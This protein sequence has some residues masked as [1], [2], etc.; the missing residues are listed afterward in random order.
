MPSDEE[1]D[2]SRLAIFEKYE[3]GR[4]GG[5]EV[6]DWEDPNLQLYAV[7]DR[8]GFMHKERL[9]PTTPSEKDLE[10]MRQRAL[11]W[12][13]MIGRWETHSDTPM[14]R[15]RIFKGVPDG[16]RTVVWSKLL[17]LD[18]IR[19]EGQYAAAYYAAR[20]KGNYR[21]IEQIDKDI[22][23]RF[24]EH[25][26]F[27]ER[28]GLGQQTLFRILA[29][30]TMYNQELGYCQGMDSIAGLLMMYMSEEDA[31]WGMCRLMSSEKFAMHGLYVNEL[32][33]VREMC[34]HHGTIRQKI[35]PKVNQHLES[36][37][38]DP[39]LYGTKWFMEG[40]QERLPFSLVLRIW[41]VYLYVGDDVMHSMAAL[42][43]KMFKKQLLKQSFE[44][45]HEFMK[46]LPGRKFDND[47][48]LDSLHE[49]L[50]DL[51]KQKL[52]RIPKSASAMFIPSRAPPEYPEPPPEFRSVS[53]RRSHRTSTPNLISS[54]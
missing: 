31:Y 28:Y 52:S 5:V 43:L 42:L 19:V 45:L 46:E 21:D 38:F 8:Y 30:Y 3:T 23:R 49:M 39:M 22:A 1:A 34:A 48:V 47:E 36:M 32:P 53:L 6:E 44:E 13:R 18:E 25:V 24:R 51:S 2:A 54:I 35:M 7:T 4:E 41:D 40:F 20:E 50:Q 10:V 14:F 11:K 12:T 29:A 37:G 33:K 17:D 26:M 27:R 15:R 16:V 9:P